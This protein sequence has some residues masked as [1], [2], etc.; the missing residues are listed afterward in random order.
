MLRALPVLTMSEMYNIHNDA[1]ARLHR[2]I[3]AFQDRL[4]INVTWVKFTLPKL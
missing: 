1:F 4:T 2:K 3:V